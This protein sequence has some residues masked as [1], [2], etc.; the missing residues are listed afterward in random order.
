MGTIR[1][2]VLHPEADTRAPDGLEPGERI[3]DPHRRGKSIEELPEPLEGQLAGKGVPVLEV[4]VQRA[5]R[6]LDG[7]RDL[8]D[9]QRPESLALHDVAR[10]IEDPGADLALLPCPSLRRP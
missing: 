4:E 6:V 1:P 10:R 7:V 2:G 5:R 8:P 3:D 9:R